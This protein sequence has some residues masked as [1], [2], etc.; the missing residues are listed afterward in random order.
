MVPCLRRNLG[1]DGLTRCADCTPRAASDAHVRDEAIGGPGQ[2][3]LDRHAIA[4]VHGAG[5]A[6]GVVPRAMHGHRTHIDTG[7]W[8]QMRRSIF[9]LQVA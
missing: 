4:F 3:A 7:R 1:R 6:R 9:S 5:E 2:D 8:T